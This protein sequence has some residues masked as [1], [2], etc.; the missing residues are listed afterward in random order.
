MSV[1]TEIAPQV[2]IPDGLAAD[3]DLPVA[4][5]GRPCAQGDVTIVAWPDLRRSAKD[6]TTPIPADGVTIAVGNGGHH[7][8][9]YGAGFFDARRDDEMVYGTL[10]VPDDG[11]VLLLHTDPSRRLS[12]EHGAVQVAAGTYRIG[13][14]REQADE[15]RR[16]AD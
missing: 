12:D 1:I 5:P 8:T 7:H 4:A 11:M 2:T 15:I 14:Q 10:T 9:L 3:V 6:A 13:G 16:V